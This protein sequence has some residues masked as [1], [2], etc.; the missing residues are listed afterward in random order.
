MN[1]RTRDDI[2]ADVHDLMAQYVTDT[3][4]PGGQSPDSA[5]DI[6][7]RI[8]DACGVT[9]DEVPAP[10]GALTS[11]QERVAVAIERAKSIFPAAIP[12]LI[13]EVA[14]RILAGH[15][16]TRAPAFPGA[17]LDRYVTPDDETACGQDEPPVGSIVRDRDGDMLDEPEAEVE[18]EPE[19]EHV[20]DV[21]KMRLPGG[22]WHCRQCGRTL[23]GSRP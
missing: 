5:A 9:D 20:C 6:V 15:A 23:I 13:R 21:P 18:P 16:P 11:D 10:L 22:A 1:E 12:S 17:A 7:E 19:P 14:E 2:R 4:Q 3:C 8:L